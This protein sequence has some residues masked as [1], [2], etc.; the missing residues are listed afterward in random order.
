MLQNGAGAVPKSVV[1][2]VGVRPGGLADAA[3]VP[4]AVVV[5]DAAVE[6][7][8]EVTRAEQRTGV[9]DQLPDLGRP[10]QQIQQTSVRRPG[11]GA[12]PQDGDRM[13]TRTGCADRPTVEVNVVGAGTRRPRTGHLAGLPGRQLRAASRAIRAC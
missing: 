2:A 7:G 13:R 3:D 8:R 11:C 4:L 12:L 10:V 5:R 1:A 6:A 9:V